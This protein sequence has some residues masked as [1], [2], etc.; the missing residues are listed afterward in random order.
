MNGKKNV[1]YTKIIITSLVSLLFLSSCA[2]THSTQ[3][4]A[5]Y[6]GMTKWIEKGLVRSEPDPP[7]LWVTNYAKYISE[8]PVE[9]KGIYFV[10]MGEG[11]SIVE[12]KDD[13]QR[14]LKD[15]Y[16]ISHKDML[17]A[18]KQTYWEQRQISHETQVNNVF[19]YRYYLLLKKLRQPISFTALVVPGLPQIRQEIQPKGSIL[20][21]TGLTGVLTAVTT[22]LLSLR[23][24]SHYLEADSSDQID[25]YQNQ[26]KM[27]S[28]TA[29]LG[30][31]LYIVSGIIS[32]FDWSNEV[33][34]WNN[35]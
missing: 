33:K 14:I 5:P 29:V 28:T 21:G 17:E 22:S 27:L 34:D 19:P 18:V 32:L 11:N 4:A 24:Y 3:E 13:A 2:T 16:G 12:A 10:V 20:L 23:S 25:Y 6:E 30:G 35:R 31:A 9:Q 15:Q 1:R 26:Y 8:L 7:P